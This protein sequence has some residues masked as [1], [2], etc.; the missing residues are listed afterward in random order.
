KNKSALYL[1]HKNLGRATLVYWNDLNPYQKAEERDQVIQEVQQSFKDA[2]KSNIKDPL[3]KFYIALM[4]DFKDFVQTPDSL[5]CLPA[6][7]RYEEAIKLYKDVEKVEIVDNNFFALLELGHLLVSRD[8]YKI[9][10]NLKHT[11]WDD[12]NGYQ[13]AIELYNKLQVSNQNAKDSVLL[14][15][16]KAQLLNAQAQLLNYNREKAQN[17]REKAQEDLKKA[18][19]FFNQ[20]KNYFEEILKVE[21]KAYQIR[22]YIGN[23]YVL[24]KGQYEKAIE[25]YDKVTENPDT[26]LY[27]YALRDSGF[28]YYM[29]SNYK[30]AKNRFI[31]ALNL[32]VSQT[33]AEKE[34]RVL[35]E[36][37]LEKI[38][39]DQCDQIDNDD[40]IC[41][42]EYRTSLKKELFDAGFFQSIFTV[43]DKDRGTDPFID[44]EH[45]KFYTCRNDPEF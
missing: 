9:S 45:D 36:K 30:K 37:Y 41:N 43:H 17:N 18:Q 16:A 42:F 8:A 44:V 33:R 20:T 34:E 15:K 11:Y 31:R 25:E 7:K 5:D 28:A 3:V 38:E 35:M 13:K 22:Y 24:D 14:S 4:D 29:T 2:E 32:E 21:P 12:L 40:N 6:S 27:Y 1:A 10:K 23:S 26:E 39:N 19:R